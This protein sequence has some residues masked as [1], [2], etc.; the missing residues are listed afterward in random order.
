MYSSNSGGSLP[1]R[2]RTDETPNEADPTRA[3]SQVHLVRPRRVSKQ[4]SRVLFP[5]LLTIHETNL[6]STSQPSPVADTYAG[7]PGQRASRVYRPI[8]SV[9]PAPTVRANLI[10]SHA[11]RTLQARR[12]CHRQ[13]FTST[14]DQSSQSPAEENEQIIPNNPTNKRHGRGGFNKRPLL[15]LRFQMLSALGSRSPVKLVVRKPK[16]IARHFKCRL[17]EM[18]HRLFTRLRHKQVV[19]SGTSLITRLGT[20]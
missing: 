2:Y 16:K 8:T 6:G 17:S 12:C 4:L 9:D 10:H 19:A 1:R 3:S 11:G 13:S 20:P 7:Q 18:V 15:R 14:P 5:K